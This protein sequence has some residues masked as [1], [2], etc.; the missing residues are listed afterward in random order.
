MNE[1][2]SNYR[3]V[4]F[5]VENTKGKV[6]IIIRNGKIV[7]VVGSRNGLTIFEKEQL[8][9]IMEDISMDHI[10]ELAEQ[11]KKDDGY[12]KKKVYLVR[13]E[14]IA[15]EDQIAELRR[16]LQRIRQMA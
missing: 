9:D 8:L 15:I 12:C 2:K 10:L 1:K 13:C 3:S 11:L 6:K 7:K 14:K 4:Q 5:C 16:R